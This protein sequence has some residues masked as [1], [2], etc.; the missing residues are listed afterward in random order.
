MVVEVGMCEGASIVM[1]DM[2]EA[3]L[4]QLPVI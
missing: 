4:H 3:V 1:D 2:V